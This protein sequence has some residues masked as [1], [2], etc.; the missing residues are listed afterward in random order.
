MRA[1]HIYI[2][3]LSPTLNLY[4]LWALR[5]IILTSDCQ[6]Q[7]YVIHYI[8]IHYTTGYKPTGVQPLSTVCQQQTIPDIPH[9]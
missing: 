5:P 6:R 8:H 4:R 1:E 7:L 9:R 3:I 2:Y